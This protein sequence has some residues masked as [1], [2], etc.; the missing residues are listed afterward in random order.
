M[1]KL[2]VLT[3]LGT[4]KAYRFEADQVSSSPRLQPVDAYDN[5]LGDGKPS[6]IIRRRKLA[7]GGSETAN[8]PVGRKM[9]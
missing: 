2:V 9:H 4:F 6:G 1:N 5:I 8:A 3:D 7:S